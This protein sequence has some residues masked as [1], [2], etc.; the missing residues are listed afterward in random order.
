MNFW[1]LKSSTSPI[2]RTLCRYVAQVVQ[3]TNKY[4]LHFASGDSPS[5]SSLSLCSFSVQSETSFSLVE[6]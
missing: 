1:R 6:N 2:S 3:L 5:N 4:C